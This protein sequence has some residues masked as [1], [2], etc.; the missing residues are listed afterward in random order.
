MYSKSFGER[1][2]DTLNVTLL[3]GACLLIIIPFA[4]LLAASFSS[5]EALIHNLVT[6]LPVDSTLDNYLLV[7]HNKV[8]WNSFRISLI[9]T[10]VGTV[11][12]MY[13]TLLTAYPL[14]RPTF[15]GKKW[16]LLGIV[17]TMIF[18][19][20]L[21]PMYL[22]VKSLGMMNTLWAIMIP[23]A[24]GAFNLIL[25][26]TFFRGLP[27]ELTE[28]AKMDGMGD[29]GILW[30]IF[31]PL[32]LPIVMTLT[33]FYA[34]GHW[35]NYMGPLFF[36]TDSGIKPLQLYL[37]SLLSQFNTQDSFLNIPESISEYSPLGIQMATVGVATLPVLMIYPFIQKHF[38]RGALL[39]SVKE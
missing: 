38:I 11:I 6:F 37:Y 1:S 28:A 7:W 35:N 22:V 15:K 26:I 39:G 25:C 21:I 13:F 17:F 36:I 32:S 2:F 34:V 19:A 12:N 31:M 8:F 23:N 33:L 9:V 18:S 14:S 27:E 10:I 4:H 16:I 20:P 30:R 24:I 29:N 3:I 5:R